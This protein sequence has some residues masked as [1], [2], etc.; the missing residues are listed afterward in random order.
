[1][2]QRPRSLYRC[3]MYMHTLLLLGVVAK[4]GVTVGKM[5]W[6]RDRSSWSLA[7]LDGKDLGYFDYVVATDKNVASTSFSGLTGRPPPLGLF[8]SFHNIIQ[9][10][11]SSFG[12]QSCFLTSSTNEMFITLVNS[13]ILITI[14]VGKMLFILP[15]ATSFHASGSDCVYV[16]VS[17]GPCSL[18]L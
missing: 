16:S 4:F 10:Y 18:L 13:S 14:L 2:F 15:K 6:L 7:S 9:Y 17:Y 12:T 8:Y 5:D 3:L 11:C 1:M